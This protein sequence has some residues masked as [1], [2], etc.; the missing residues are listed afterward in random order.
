MNVII[1]YLIPIALI[2]YGILALNTEI[3]S[4]RGHKVDG[5]LYI[6]GGIFGLVLMIVLEIINFLDERKKENDFALKEQ[7]ATQ[8]NK[9]FHICMLIPVFVIIYFVLLYSNFY[10]VQESILL[11]VVFALYCAQKKLENKGV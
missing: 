10:Y 1:R 9:N 6:Y 5:M 4:E 11:I 7:E 3:I 8:K 2:G